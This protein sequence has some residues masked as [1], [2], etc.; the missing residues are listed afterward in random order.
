M[1]VAIVSDSGQITIPKDILSKLNLN[2]GDAIVFQ[3]ENGSFY[4][5]NAAHVSFIRSKQANIKAEQA[6]DTP[7]RSSS[8]ELSEEAREIVLDVADNIS[9]RTIYEA[10]NATV[11]TK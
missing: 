10:I 1:Y 4:I 9:Y 11:G 7:V 2:A 5:D 3:E 6:D 8:L